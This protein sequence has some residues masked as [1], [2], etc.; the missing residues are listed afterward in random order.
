V[1]GA[2]TL[3]PRSARRLGKTATAQSTSRQSTVTP[4]AV[5]KVGVTSASRSA[6]APSPSPGTSWL[7]PAGLRGSSRGSAAEPSALVCTTSRWSPAMNP[8]PVTVVAPPSA[9]NSVVS[10]VTDGVGRSAS[11]NA[12]GAHTSWVRSAW[13]PKS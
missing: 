6:N 4:S 2:N 13:S 1:I 3:W 5:V 9:G 8:P 11:S 10:S 12:I 7:V